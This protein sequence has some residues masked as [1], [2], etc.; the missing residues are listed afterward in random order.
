MIMEK[1]NF[2]RTVRKSGTSFSINIP[3]E[4][5]KILNLKKGDIVR[6]DVGKVKR[7]S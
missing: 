4:V 2:V 1:E 5:I 7:G 3:P 6:V